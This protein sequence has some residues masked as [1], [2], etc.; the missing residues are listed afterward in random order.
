[1]LDDV[2]KKLSKRK[3][4]DIKGIGQIA[5]LNSEQKQQL[6]EFVKSVQTQLD[7]VGI[8]FLDNWTTFGVINPD[9]LSENAGTRFSKDYADLSEK[10]FISMLKLVSSVEELQGIALRQQYLN[11]PRLKQ[12]SK[13]QID[14]IKQ[15]KWELEHG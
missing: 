2:S 4:T 5:S 9:V 15:R 1:M 7:T 14:L 8:N 13:W 3:W 6:K 10:D 11:T 12:Y